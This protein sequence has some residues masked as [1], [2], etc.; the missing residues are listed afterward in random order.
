[1][2]YELRT[3]FSILISAY[4]TVPE[5]FYNCGGAT[6]ACSDLLY[7]AGQ[8]TQGDFIRILQSLARMQMLSFDATSPPSPPGRGIPAYRLVCELMSSRHRPQRLEQPERRSLPA[9]ATEQQ[10]VETILKQR[11]P[12]ACAILPLLATIPIGGDSENEIP[13]RHWLAIAETE[14]T[15]ANETGHLPVKLK[16]VLDLFEKVFGCT[17]T[18]ARE[19]L[20]SAFVDDPKSLFL[21]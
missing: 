9:Y 12:E 11:A 5:A 1:M 10:N 19:V 14:L 15:V 17:V 6:L 13:F 7:E 3:K 16:S 18:D 2:L 21:M 4:G 8:G 20:G